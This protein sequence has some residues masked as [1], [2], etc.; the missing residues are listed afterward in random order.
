[1]SEVSEKIEEVKEAVAEKAAEVK[2]TVAGKVAE[3]KEAVAEQVAELKEAAPEKLAEA[4]EAVAGKVAEVKEAAPEKLAEVKEAVAE[5]VAEAK[6]TVAEKAEEV[7]EAAKAKVSEPAKAEPMEN[8]AAELEQSLQAGPPKNDDPVW[9][10]FEQML[11]DKTIFEVKIDSAVKGGVVAF[12][13][14]VRAFIPASKL[15]AGYV[16]NLEEYKG[17]TIE[18]IVITA[19]RENKKLVLSGRDAA[20]MRRDEQRAAAQAKIE[21][22]AVLEGKVESLKDYG[23]FVDLG[24]GVSGLV[25]VSQISYK[26]VEKP[27]DVLKEGDTVKVK[28]IGIKDGK[29]SLSMKALEEA[30][31]RAPREDRPERSDRPERGERRGRREEKQEYTEKEKA[32]TSMADL[33]AGIKLD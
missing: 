21:L 12:V 9:D 24:D 17:K 30:P 16:E 5:A 19:D 2:E 27:A 28:V 4:K 1:M 29:I 8:Y 18:A 14:D 31:K 22:D 20:R 32:T 7:K 10:K 13:D 25:H 26:R 23:A 15:A 6:E 11:A 33:L 3:A